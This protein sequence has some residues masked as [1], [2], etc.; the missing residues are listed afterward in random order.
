M[1]FQSKSIAKYYSLPTETYTLYN[2]PAETKILK[3]GAANRQAA[4]F[5]RRYT[6][7][8][9]YQANQWVYF[10]HNHLYNKLCHYI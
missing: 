10:L 5:I 7:A 8:T 6:A 1:Y 4:I 9:P 2:L 3:N